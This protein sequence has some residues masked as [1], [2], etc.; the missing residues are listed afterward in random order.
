MK[1]VPFRAGLD[2]ARYNESGDD[3]DA[4]VEAIGFAILLLAALCVVAAIIIGAVLLV[5]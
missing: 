4:E 3:A 5:W 1:E 2:Y